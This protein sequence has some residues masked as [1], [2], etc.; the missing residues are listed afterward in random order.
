MS[1]I[2]KTGIMCKYCVIEGTHRLIVLKELY[3]L[4]TEIK[5]KVRLTG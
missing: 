4:N 2:L 5:I 3:P 1:A